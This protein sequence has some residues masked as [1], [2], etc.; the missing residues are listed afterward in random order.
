MDSGCAVDIV[1]EPGHMY[2]CAFQNIFSCIA[3]YT[4]HCS[5]QQDDS[6]DDFLLVQKRFL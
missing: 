3:Y 2:S 4:L 5:R 6:V 1:D